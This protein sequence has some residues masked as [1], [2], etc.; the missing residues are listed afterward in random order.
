[1][2]VVRTEGRLNVK[3]YFRLS[4]YLQLVMS[5]DAVSDELDLWI[6]W[7]LHLHIML[8]GFSLF[9]VDELPL[10]CSEF[11]VFMAEN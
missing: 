2:K 4:F 5:D 11:R 3:L 1:M 7:P 10:Q 9:C 6:I 8:T